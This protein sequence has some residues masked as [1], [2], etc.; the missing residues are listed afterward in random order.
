MPPIFLNYRRRQ[1][2]D[3]ALII[4]Q[5]LESRLGAGC[6]FLDEESV[7]PGREWPEALRQGVR[8][9][10]VLLALIHPDWHKDQEESGAKSLD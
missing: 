9:C 6:T 4:R 7:E 10:Q 1:S 8:E 2:R 5:L 3:K